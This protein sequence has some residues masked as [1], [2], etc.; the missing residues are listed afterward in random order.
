MI[1]YEWIGSFVTLVGAISSWFCYRL[2]RVSSTAFSYPFVS[3]LSVQL[4][5][6]V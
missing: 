5:I 2:S 3:T 4:F 6:L 1:P